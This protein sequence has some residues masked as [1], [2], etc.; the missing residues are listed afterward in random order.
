V[1]IP[2]LDLFAN[3]IIFQTNECSQGN[4]QLLINVK[5][6]Q[7]FPSNDFV[8]RHNLMYFTRFVFVIRKE[9]YLHTTNYLI[10]HEKLIILSGKLAYLIRQLS[11][12]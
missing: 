10:I 3:Q 4:C 9:I 7:R 8:D 1:I 12:I 5:I 6:I 11:V 2:V